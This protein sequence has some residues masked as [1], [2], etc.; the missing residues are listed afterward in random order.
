ME[1]INPKD[2]KSNEELYFYWWLKDLWKAGY[3]ESA[4]Y[5][6]NSFKFGGL[7]TE[8][9]KPLKRSNKIEKE[10]LLA[11]TVYTMDFTIVWNPIARH[12][13]FETLEDSS[14]LKTTH[15]KSVTICIAHQE[16]GKYVSY[17]EIKPIFDHK[18]MTM[19]AKRNII[20]TWLVHKKFVN[21]I[22]IPKWFQYS[23]TPTRFLFTNR[24]KKVRK[25]SYDS[26][27]I[28]EYCNAKAL[29]ISNKN[30]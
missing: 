11:E 12:Y 25:L 21:L 24:N 3:I 18:N 17:V 26:R 14:K 2:F 20:M 4:F 13:F 15:N 7:E 30:A 16:N 9:T 10:I 8:Y 23:F 1:T 6:L 5:E 29:Q 28:E 22:K 27:T 19:M